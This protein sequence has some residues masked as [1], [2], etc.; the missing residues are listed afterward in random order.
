MTYYLRF[1][2]GMKKFVCGAS[3]LQLSLTWPKSAYYDVK[4]SWT[5]VLP[6]SSPVHSLWLKMIVVSITP[7]K[8]NPWVFIII[9]PCPCDFTSD[10]VPH[11]VHPFCQ[12][13]VIKADPTLKLVSVCKISP[14]VGMISTLELRKWS[15]LRLCHWDQWPFFIFWGPLFL[16]NI[17]TRFLYGGR[18]VTPWYYCRSYNTSTV[19]LQYFYSAH[20]SR[21]LVKRVS[22][23]NLN[24]VW[25]FPF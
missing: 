21:N 1:V 22:N 6:C 10:F 13:V 2:T 15:C 12:A 17:E 8:S 9:E 20:C 19:A 5:Q 23:S 16:R 11:L 25:S 14:I 7:T 24:S 18:V 4:P 3:L